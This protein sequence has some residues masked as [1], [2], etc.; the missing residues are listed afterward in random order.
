[1]LLDDIK[2]LHINNMDVKEL[3]L[4]NNTIWTAEQPYDQ[5]LDTYVRTPAG[6]G[7][8][9]N[10]V[11]KHNSQINMTFKQQGYKTTSSYQGDR[12]VIYGAHDNFYFT[13]EY[14][15]SNRFYWYYNNGSTSG[16]ST[17]TTSSYTMLKYDS[18]LTI[19]VKEG[20]FR[21][22]I[23]NN[24]VTTLDN[25]KEIYEPLVIGDYGTSGVSWKNRC[26]VCV[27]SL[28]IYED[29]ILVRDYVPAQKGDKYGLYD[30]KTGVFCWETTHANG[31]GCFWCN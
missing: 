21:S 17:T 28:K 12:Y 25:A 23:M 4:N 2:S 6:G 26:V 27:K 16:C 18:S 13:V 29:G 20:L 1:M 10:Y 30:H 7:L 15:G 9:L 8:I 24:T 14:G 31:D 3:I 11:P 22:S 19:D 5:L